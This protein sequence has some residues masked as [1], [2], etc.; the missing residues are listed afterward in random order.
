M[1]AMKGIAEKRNLAFLRSL[2][3]FV[4]NFSSY[5]FISS[6]ASIPVNIYL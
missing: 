1:E 6:I 2:R 5:F 4:A 3:S